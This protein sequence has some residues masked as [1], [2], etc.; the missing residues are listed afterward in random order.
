MTPSPQLAARGLRPITEL[1]QGR[2]H[3][4]RLRYLAG[5]RCADCRRA[6]TAYE[7]A[8]A[9]ARK[10]GDW[11]GIVS[12]A[13]AR[14][15]LAALAKLGVGRRAVGDACDVADSTLSAI[16]TFRKL[17]IR[18]RTERAI[19]AVTAEAAADRA[20]IPAA[21]T[22]RYLDSL[23]ADG[24]SKAEL[25]RYLGYKVP[26]LQLGRDKVT[27]RNAHDVQRMYLRLCRVNAAPTVRRLNALADEGYTRRAIREKL[28]ALAARYGEPGQVDLAVR[29]GRVCA[30]TERYVLMLYRQVIE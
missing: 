12:A 20:L 1:A 10:A 22:W 23:I 4:D 13:K 6:N 17:S 8:R 24:Y 26:A 25:A 19:L 18:A 3:G 14:D 9:K 2:A 30:H 16:I 5:C 11:N 29:R 28:D 7:T 21:E 15:H 27:V